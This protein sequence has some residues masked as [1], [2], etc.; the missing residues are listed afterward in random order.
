MN[1]SRRVVVYTLLVLLGMVG[2]VV[3]VFGDKPTETKP[4]PDGAAVHKLLESF[5]AAFNSG[6]AKGCAA[7]FTEAGEFVDDDGN[8]VTGTA[9]IEVL[10]TKFF[11]D[12]KGAKLQLTPSG[13]RTIAPGVA[14]EDGESVV[15]VPEKAT[16]SSR[17]YA[18]VFA[19]V[20]GNWK[21]A[22]ARE[23]PEEGQDIPIAERLKPLEFL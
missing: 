2:G 14:V 19:K 16:Q 12:N 7:S 17:T 23:Y 20:D 9:E 22:S 13:T 3:T 18:M 15:T 5:A 6:D 1:V 4:S 21:I 11:A 8:R 10:F